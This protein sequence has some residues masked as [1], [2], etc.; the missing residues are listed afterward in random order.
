MSAFMANTL[1]GK[2]WEN[3][4]VHAEDD[5]MGTT[6]WVDGI[7]D[8]VSRQQVETPDG[9]TLLGMTEAGGDFPT[10]THGAFACLAHDIGTSVVEHVLAT[11][12]LSQKKSVLA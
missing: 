4:V 7:S 3:H 8:P 10:S 9:A 6:C 5:G 11:Q 2:L 1:H 12:S